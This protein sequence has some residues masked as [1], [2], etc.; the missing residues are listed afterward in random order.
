METESNAAPGLLAGRWEQT[1]THWFR[2]SVGRFLASVTQVGGTGFRDRWKWKVYIFPTGTHLLLDEGYR[3]TLAEAQ[4][5]CEAAAEAYV[6]ALRAE[7][8]EWG[9]TDA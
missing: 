5:A 1:G 2:A 4:A 7:L 3:P 6:A 8:A 9:P